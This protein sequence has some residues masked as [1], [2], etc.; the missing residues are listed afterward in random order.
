MNASD[1][2]SW[3]STHLKTLM[4][5]HSPLR[6]LGTIAIAIFIGETLVMLILALLPPLPTFTE[7]ITDSTLLIVVTSPA[8]YFF[9]FQPLIRHIQQREAAKRSLRKNRD[10]LQTVFNGIS[11]PLILLDRKS[12]VKMINDAAIR[13]YRID[14]PL[15]D[16]Q[17]CHAVFMSGD[18][19]CPECEIPS[20]IAE[21]AS[22][23]FERKGL[24]DPSRTEQ[25][26]IYRSWDQ[27]NKI[28]A[29][30]LKI[31]DVTE[32][33][34]LERQINQ[35]ERLASLGLLISGVAHEINNP[36]T[37]ISFNLPI[38]RDYLNEMIPIIDDYAH[39]K[40]DFEIAN[41]PYADFR[42]DLFK[43]IE[44]ITHGSRRID[45]IVSQLKE[46]SRLRE[47]HQMG[48]VD[49]KGVVERVVTLANAQI[50]RMVKR[51]ELEVAP[52]LPPLFT[53][54]QAIEQV[55]LNLLINAGQAADKPDSWVRL[56]AYGLSSEPFSVCLEVA[57]NGCGMDDQTLNHIF[58]PLFTTKS[59][60]IGTGLGLY[61][62][63]NLVDA[64]G[65][66]IEVSSTVGEGSVF[67]VLLPDLRARAGLS[68]AEMAAASH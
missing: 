20:L 33:R 6:I 7:A 39:G 55:V 62:C 44:N 12:R 45:T 51:F 26:V 8:L 4:T 31:T 24:F 11:D 41:M 50:K 13:Y 65:G 53:D 23:T 64:L 25:V 16:G 57:D 42:Q 47:K 32:A 40:T 36:N 54:S 5:P 30:I 28:G 68:R 56:K 49:V 1:P 67:Q 15:I 19:P 35:R 43:L 52:D 27:A 37:F 48:E 14:E 66:L 3:I 9:L 17:P 60:D 22:H 34:A 2:K 10:L 18:G 38:L 21:N 63:H 61:I 46:F 58:D 59:P 29:A